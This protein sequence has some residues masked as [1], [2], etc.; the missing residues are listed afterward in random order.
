MV[1][2]DRESERLSDFP[3]VTQQQNQDQK[4]DLSWARA[5]S[6]TLV[7]VQGLLP[8]WSQIFFFLPLLRFLAYL[9]LVESKH[10]GNCLLFLASLACAL[11]CPSPS[12]SSC[13][14]RLQSS[15]LLPVH[16]QPQV[17]QLLTHQFIYLGGQ[18]GV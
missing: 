9:F 16:G 4:S 15:P 7:E 10:R 8:V 2:E 5:H 12:P 6:T 3:Q 11:P 13:L 18:Q 1:N 17:L 14:R